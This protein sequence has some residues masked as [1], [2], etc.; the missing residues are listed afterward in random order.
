MR[1]GRPAPY[2]ITRARIDGQPLA[3]IARE[4]GL[5]RAKLRRILE[6][7]SLYCFSRIEPEMVR[8]RREVK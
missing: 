3:R 7:H 8:R 5:T 4:H 1:R 6:D 2:A